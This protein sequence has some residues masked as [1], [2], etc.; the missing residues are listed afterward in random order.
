VGANSL[1]WLKRLTLEGE[2]LPE[3]YNKVRGKL[4]A[5]GTE[6]NED[7]RAL[8]EELGELGK[9]LGNTIDLDQTATCYFILIGQSMTNKILPKK[10]NKPRKD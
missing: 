10:S 4:L 2:D 9:K 3:L 1:T 6:G 8:I 5:Y 7:V